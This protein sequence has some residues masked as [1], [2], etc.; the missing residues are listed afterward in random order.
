MDKCKFFQNE[1]EY[2]GHVI[3][4]EGIHPQPAKID[5]IT[6]HSV[7]KNQAELCSFL[8]MVN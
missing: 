4:K 2:L 5:A 3:D 6:Q 7:S 8:G 1:I